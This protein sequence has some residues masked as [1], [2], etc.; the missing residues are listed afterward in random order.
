MA[1][2]ALARSL[3]V[4]LLTCA[5]FSGCSREEGVG[6]EIA[7][8]WAIEPA[9][10]VAGTETIARITLRDEDR[11]PI[12]GARLRLEGHMSHPGMAPVVADVVERGDGTY[13]APLHFS[14]AGDWVL[15]MTGELADG[16]RIT[17]DVKVAGVRSVR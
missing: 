12:A 16:R 13:E 5:V 6:G 3:R 7:A 15:V 9:A 8:V 10:P 2:G 11:Q 1:P 4:G 17:K 14:M